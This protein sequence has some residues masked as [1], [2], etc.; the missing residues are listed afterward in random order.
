MGI[1]FKIYNDLG[2]GYQEKY[3]QNALKHAFDKANIPYLEQVRA[4]L[5]SDGKFIGRYYMDFIVNHKIVLEVKVKC[6]FTQKDIRQVLGYLKRSNLD[7]GILVSFADTGIKY[8][9]ILRGYH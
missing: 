5:I 2:G 4:D 3:Y 8:K 1:L 6:F 7:L 9:R